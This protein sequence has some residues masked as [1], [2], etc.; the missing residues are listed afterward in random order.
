MTENPRKEFTLSPF[1]LWV[2]E[3]WFLNKDERLRHREAELELDE[4]W[5]MNKW[6]L[7][8]EY[9]RRLHKKRGV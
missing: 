2:Q 5:N 7:K 1:R 3:L 8:R 9:Q 6:W 4:Y